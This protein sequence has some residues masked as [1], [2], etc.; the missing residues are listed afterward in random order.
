MKAGSAIR[1]GH[2]QNL[3]KVAPEGVEALKEA[4]PSVDYVLSQ[5]VG[6]IQAGMGYVGAANLE[7]LRKKARFV[8]VTSA[9]RRE[10]GPHDIIEIKT[11]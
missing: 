4:A 11:G 9:G 2:S 7:E 1:Y 3:Q 6:G 8:R 10:A 5:L